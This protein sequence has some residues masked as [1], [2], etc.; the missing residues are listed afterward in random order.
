MIFLDRAPSFL[1]RLRSSF[2]LAALC[3][4][5]AV[6]GLA[7]CANH[8]RGDITGSIQKPLTTN[9]F[10]AA[11]DYWGKRYLREPGNKQV[12]LNYAAALGR[13]DRNDQAV[14]ILQ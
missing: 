3:V 9:D 6:I 8:Q 10:R 11:A 5:M 12:A 7:G 13:L 1:E 14:A 2:R 4:P